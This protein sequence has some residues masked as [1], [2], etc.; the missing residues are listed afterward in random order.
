MHYILL[1]CNILFDINN[2]KSADN[3]EEVVCGVVWTFHNLKIYTESLKDCQY[4][5][6]FL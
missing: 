5:R 3:Q 1:L 4:L 2:S 6:K